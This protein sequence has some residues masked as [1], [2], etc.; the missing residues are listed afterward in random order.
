MVLAARRREGFGGPRGFMGVQSPSPSGEGSVT[1][2]R[3]AAI[4]P[5]PHGRRAGGLGRERPRARSRPAG[6]PTPRPPT[7]A[8]VRARRG[9]GGRERGR[10]RGR[11][12]VARVPDRNRGRPGGRRRVAPQPRARTD[13]GPAPAA[14]RTQQE[15]DRGPPRRLRKPRGLPRPTSRG[16]R[17]RG[18]EVGRRGRRTALLPAQPGTS[19]GGRG[20]AHP[21]RSAAGPV[22]GLVPRREPGILH[23]RDGGRVGHLPGDRPLPHA[24]AARPG[25]RRTQA[26]RSSL[27]VPAPRPARG[28]VD[29]VGDAFPGPP[30]TDR[31]PSRET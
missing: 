17:G 21:L 15:P 20:H 28:W 12:A 9:V 3:L 22:R 19:L 7:V 5:A 27:R 26:E 31:S 6:S 16:E 30:D 29:R 18:D 23:A 25:P 10:W 2:Q 11:P 4:A 14:S 1:E 8:Q 24:H 13:R